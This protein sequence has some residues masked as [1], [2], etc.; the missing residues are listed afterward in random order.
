M[1]KES[2]FPCRFLLFLLQ[3][4]RLELRVKRDEA[5]TIPHLSRSHTL[6]TYLAPKHRL[7][8]YQRLK[9]HIQIFCRQQMPAR[10]FVTC[11]FAVLT[12]QLFGHAA[13]AILQGENFFFHCALR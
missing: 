1:V 8:L 10:L 11:R 6:L 13:L 9:Q 4:A 3:T 12:H 7:L 5:L 2:S